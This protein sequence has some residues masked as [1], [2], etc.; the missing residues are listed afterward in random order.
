VEKIIIA[1]GLLVAGVLLA[2]GLYVLYLLYE[3]SIGYPKEILSDSARG[4]CVVST[5]DFYFAPKDDKYLGERIFDF[6]DKPQGKSYVYMP[7]RAG[8]IRTQDGQEI[9]DLTALRYVS[10]GQ[11]F[12]LKAGYQNRNLNGSS[13]YYLLEPQGIALDS[14]F[15][16]SAG[17]PTKLNLDDYSLFNDIQG[18]ESCS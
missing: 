2:G 1:F 8:S 18:F 16:I 17:L 13:F 9:Y 12:V 10:K 7:Y 15:I 11:R 3:P 6:F 14:S 5:Y 4:K